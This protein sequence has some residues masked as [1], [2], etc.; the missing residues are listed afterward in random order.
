M[1]AEQRGRIAA[2]NVDA[3]VKFA[4]QAEQ[5]TGLSRNLYFIG[6]N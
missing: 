5:A 1:E 3:I 2:L 6:I 4:S